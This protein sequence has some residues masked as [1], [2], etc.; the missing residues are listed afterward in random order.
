MLQNARKT[1]II[2]PAA[3]V[4]P[5]QGTLTIFFFSGASCLRIIFSISEPHK[6]QQLSALWHRPGHNGTESF[7]WRCEKAV[8]RFSYSFIGRISVLR[9]GSIRR[10]TRK[11]K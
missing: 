2:D 6:L 1:T 8:W 9:S 7:V 10:L 11:R 4:L 5:A 3:V